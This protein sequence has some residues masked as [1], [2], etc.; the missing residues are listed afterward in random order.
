[1]QDQGQTIDLAGNTLTLGSN[2]TPSGLILNGGRITGGTLK[3]TAEALIYTSL[4]GG[5]IE[6]QITNPGLRGLTFFGPGVAKLTG[7]SSGIGIASTITVNSGTLQ[8]EGR[9]GGHIVLGP[10]GTLAGAGQLSGSVS[11]G[12]ASPGNGAA[13][14]ILTADSVWRRDNTNA[15]ANSTTFD[16]ELGHIGAPDFGQPTASGNDLLRLTNPTAAFNAPFDSSNIISLYF[17]TSALQLGDTFYGGL[18]TDLRA[19]FT[20]SIADATFHFYLR[21]PNG[22]E[23]FEGQ[24]YSLAGADEFAISTAALSADF[25]SGQVDGQIMEIQV[26]PEPS[27]GGLLLAALGLAGFARPKRLLSLK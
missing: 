12:V 7:D 21:D 15:V 18:Y 3:I 10:D 24:S 13:A 9:L 8:V 2:L 26:V 19:D 25:G 5:A 14:A 4:A 20:S 11:G 23:L 16:F 6:S 27:S 17:D 1:L 22:T